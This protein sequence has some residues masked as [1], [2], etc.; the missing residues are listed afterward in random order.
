MCVGGWG[1][2]CDVYAV[3][4]DVYAVKCDVYAVRCDVYAVKCDVYAF[5][6][7][8]PADSALA[9]LNPGGEMD[10]NW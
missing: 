2:K 4:C 6:L 9:L 3:K 10:R 5:G 7:S 8:D 1:L